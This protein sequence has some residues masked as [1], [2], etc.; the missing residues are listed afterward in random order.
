[1]PPIRINKH[2]Q[3]H[4]QD[5]YGPAI[6]RDL[7]AVQTL[8]NLA[9]V[10][11]AGLWGFNASE[12]LGVGAAAAESRWYFPG[13]LRRQH[14]FSEWKFISSAAGRYMG[15]LA[16]ASA[17]GAGSI[18]YYLLGIKNNTTVALSTVTGAGTTD[19]ATAAITA[20]EENEL[21]RLES[22]V[23][24]SYAG[25]AQTLILD[26]IS[27]GKA[28]NSPG[29]A[30]YDLTLVA[31]PCFLDV[32]VDGGTV[33]VITFASTD[34]LIAAF[35]AV[36]NAEV[37]AVINSQ[38]VGARAWVP[39]AATYVVI[40]TNT[41]GNAGSVDVDAAPVDDANTVLGF[42]LVAGAGTSVQVAS[43]DNSRL[44]GFSGLIGGHVGN[45]AQWARSFSL[46]GV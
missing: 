33:Q 39:A 43:S 21:F 9:E 29:A 7:I 30:N 24:T 42:S 5:R 1:M 10:A 17:P 41:W 40:A 28:S 44:R 8:E 31:D 22:W 16:R 35:N 37:A 3:N 34:P 19:L 38:I 2:A 18:G 46:D 15:M 23:L 45:T 36:T 11:G 27:Q 6:S 32:K 14:M 12:G 26:H 4:G 20:L 25:N 13:D